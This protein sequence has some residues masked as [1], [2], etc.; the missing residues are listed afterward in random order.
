MRRSFIGR[1]SAPVLPAL[2]DLVRSHARSS[3]RPPCPPQEHENRPDSKVGRLHYSLRLHPKRP[4]QVEASARP[5]VDGARY[6]RTSARRT[7]S[8]TDRTG[9][10]ATLPM[11]TVPTG[12]PFRDI[13]SISN[14]LVGQRLDSKLAPNIGGVV[15]VLLS[16]GSTAPAQFVG[17]DEFQFDG[18]RG[19][20][21]RE[22]RLG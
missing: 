22:Q 8:T 6:F 7:I 16:C 14:V 17:T 5:S 15:G 19:R 2:V 13:A 12:S 21:D 18:I 3:S 11:R 10:Y 1:S 20:V 4:I 9:Q